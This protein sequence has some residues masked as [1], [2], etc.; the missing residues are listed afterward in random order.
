MVDFIVLERTEV[1]VDVWYFKALY[2]LL[3]SEETE[4]FGQ[5]SRCM[6]PKVDRM[7]QMN[8][9]LLASLPS[10]RN[11]STAVEMEVKLRRLEKYWEEQ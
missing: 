8:G 10:A 5:V 6:G 4:N 11:K 2:K 3:G 9:T 1:E 7:F